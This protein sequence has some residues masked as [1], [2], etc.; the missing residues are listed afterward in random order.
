MTTTTPT[1][2]TPSSLNSR[3][4]LYRNVALGAV[5]V[6][7]IIILL[8]PRK[9]DI[10]TVALTAGFYAGG[11]HLTAHYTGTSIAQ[12]CANRIQSLSSDELPP[13]ALES[14]RRLKEERERRDAKALAATTTTPTAVVRRDKTGDDNGVVLAE[15]RR[16]EAED[17]SREKGLLEKVWMG[18]EGP[19]WKAKRDQREKEALEE[20]RG[21]GGLIMDQIWEVWSWTKDKAEEVKEVDEKVIRE[22]KEGRK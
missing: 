4:T 18:G 6:C 15:I 5:I 10:Y 21:Y 1:T 3:E 12:R 16:K 19:D 8:P 22:G 17:G 13:K 2:L 7:P 14:Q 20:G 9:I 11:N